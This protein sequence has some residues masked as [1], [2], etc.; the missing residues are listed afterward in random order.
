M[1][2]VG[3]LCGD[4]ILPT[5]TPKRHAWNVTGYIYNYFAYYSNEFR[6]F[7]ARFEYQ[8]INPCLDVIRGLIEDSDIDILCVNDA[9]ELPADKY[10]EAVEVMSRS[11]EKRL[12]RAGRYER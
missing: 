10:D 7:K 3:R 12:P 5:I 6:P 8:R 1:K 2:E 4:M 11:F 9:G